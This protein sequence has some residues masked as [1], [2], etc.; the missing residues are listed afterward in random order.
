MR[1]F[2]KLWLTVFFSL[3]YCYLGVKV[4]PRGLPRLISFIPVVS[5]FL[6]LPLNLHSVHL[7]GSTS[8]FVSWLA[9]FKLLLLA[10]HR[11]PLSD[12]SLS[13]LQFI[14]I[15]SLPIKI[16]QNPPTNTQNG[17]SLSSTDVDKGNSISQKGKLEKKQIKRSQMSFWAYALMGLFVTVLFRVYDYSEQIHAK[18]LMVIYS[19][20]M[21]FMLEIMLA[22][23]AAVVRIALGMELEAQF[24]KPYLSTSLQDFWGRRWNLMV[25]GIL[26][27]TVYK[28]V[29]SVAS[30]IVSPKWAQPPAMFLTF[31]VSGLMHELIF[32]YLDRVRPTWEITWFFLLHGACLLV[33]VQMKKLATGRCRLP[34]WVSA[35]LTIGF[36]IATSF[37][38]FF[39]VF[40]RCNIVV[41]AV[42]EYNSL[43]AFVK[44]V[45]LIL[46]S[47]VWDLDD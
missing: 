41:R 7:G 31:V 37:W 46:S 1:N 9:N 29:L 2:A 47:N 15:G 30:R 4:I 22:A 16:Q 19:L 27:P 38:L 32:F 40:L 11:G 25:T 20:H 35:P 6:I 18:L 3:T 28:P 36:V 33:E 43:V 44:N 42:H 12:P 23:V 10:F 45:V 8:F 34:W 14:A 24:D 17:H 13:L 39:P 5:L 26:R 21:Y